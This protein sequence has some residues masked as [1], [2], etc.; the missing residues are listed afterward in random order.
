[1]L[2]NRY[3]ISSLWIF[4]ALLSLAGRPV[5]TALSLEKLVAESD[6]ILVVERGTPFE[7]PKDDLISNFKVVG[8]LYWSGINQKPL[9]GGSLKVF[10]SGY[11]ALVKN[12]EFI[13][14]GGSGYSYAAKC[15][16]NEEGHN[17]SNWYI[18]QL[19]DK[20]FII[21]LQGSEFTAV[22]AYESLTKKQKILKFTGQP[23]GPDTH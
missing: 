5:Y 3:L 13:K 22:G 23:H 14:G 11:Q 7:N 18:K 21:F 6:L 16:V 2:K 8:I 1:M 12:R 9:V 19:P 17:R 15:Y 10:A 4:I 20:Q